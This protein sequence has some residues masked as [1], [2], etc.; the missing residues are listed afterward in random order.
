MIMIILNLPGFHTS[1]AIAVKA[2]LLWKSLVPLLERPSIV[3]HA[4]TALWTLFVLD[5]N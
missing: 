1:E 5:L 4:T 2:L 3:Y